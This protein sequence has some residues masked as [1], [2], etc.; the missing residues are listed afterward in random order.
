MTS[1]PPAA[2]DGLSSFI[3]GLGLSEPP[4]FQDKGV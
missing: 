4:A 3:G 1:T 2:P